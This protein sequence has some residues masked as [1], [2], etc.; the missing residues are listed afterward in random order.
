MILLG[1]KNF[2]VPGRIQASVEEHSAIV[3]AVA[4]RDAAQ[5]EQ[6]AR[7]HIRHGYDSR[8]RAMMEELRND[9]IER[10]RSTLHAPFPDADRRRS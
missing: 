5:A 6:A 4:V 2:A 3:E 9:A 10:S 8:V 7:L 1:E